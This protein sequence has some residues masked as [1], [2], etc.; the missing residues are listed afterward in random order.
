[1]R[2]GTV[3]WAKHS[4]CPEWPGVLSDPTSWRWFEAGAKSR[5]GRLIAGP[6]MN[7]VKAARKHKRI[8]VALLKPNRVAVG[9]R[10]IGPWLAIGR[11]WS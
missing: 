6:S 5:S 11:V 1:M 9:A 4:S 7:T 8:A 2:A 3:A 10:S